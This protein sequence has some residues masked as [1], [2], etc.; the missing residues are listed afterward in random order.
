MALLF[1]LM[2]RRAVADGADE[3]PRVLFYFRF[4][5]EGRPRLEGPLSALHRGT[6]EGNIYGFTSAHAI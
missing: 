6:K 4:L 1:L 2:E 3:L 5:V